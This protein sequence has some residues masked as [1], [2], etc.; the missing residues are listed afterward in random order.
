MPG[1]VIG[2]RGRHDN[3]WIQR[4]D[5]DIPAIHRQGEPTHMANLRI[6][7]TR[8]GVVH[9]QGI[10]QQEFALRHLQRHKGLGPKLVPVPYP[11]THYAR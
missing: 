11:L 1:D 3:L 5:G 8:S 7:A 9:L 2:K 10:S 6:V 4:T